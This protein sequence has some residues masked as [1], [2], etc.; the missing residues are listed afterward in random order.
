MKLDRALSRIG[1]W[2]GRMVLGRKSIGTNPIER[3]LSSVVVFALLLLASCTAPVQHVTPSGKVE[4]TI[5][6][7][8]AKQ[9]GAAITN[10]MVNRRYRLSKSDPNSIR[11][12]RPM[13]N[14]FAAAFFGSRYDS[15]PNVR[16]IYTL[17][18]IGDQTRVVA[19]FQIVT[20]PGSAFER[21]TA[22]NENA[23]TMEF[24]GMLIQIKSSFEAVAIIPTGSTYLGAHIQAVTGPVALAAGLEPPDRECRGRQSSGKRGAS[25]RRHHSADLQSTDEGPCRRVKLRA[26]AT[27][28]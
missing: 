26:R 16:I 14:T 3:I 11:F 4:A 19:D 13:E 22:A 23:S 25:S 28:R 9:I 15:T 6:R 8:S 18:E 21:I 27:T 2:I 10:Q 24:Q 7:A 20:N 5:S 12:E 17:I 1:C